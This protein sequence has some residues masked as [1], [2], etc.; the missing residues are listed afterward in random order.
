MQTLY[1]PDLLN[2]KEVNFLEYHH[3]NF[4]HRTT[5]NYI[6]YIKKGCVDIVTDDESIHLQEGDIFLL[7]RNFKY[8]SYWKGY[9]EISFNSYAF[10]SFPGSKPNITN[11]LKF[12]K[13]PKVSE[14]IDSI[15]LNTTL[16]CYSVGMFYLLLNELL[17]S[18]EDVEKSAEQRLLDKAMKYIQENPD[19]LIPEVASYCNICESSLYAIFKEYSN[20]SPAKFKLNVKL[21]KALNYIVSTDI[22]IEKISALCNFSSPAYFRKNFCKRYNLSPRQIRKNSML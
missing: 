7:P 10:I 5:Y 6:A 22:P 20:I 21:D 14:F 8:H 12:K 15:S 18:M 1:F 19:C 4:S 9:P 16:D 11:L 17:K 13:T 3:T 2:F